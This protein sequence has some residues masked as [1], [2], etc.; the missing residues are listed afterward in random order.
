MRSANA[1]YRLCIE[2]TWFQYTV[3]PL[4]VTYYDT[5][6]AVAVWATR[7]RTRNRPDKTG[8]NGGAI[9]D[10]MPPRKRRLVAVQK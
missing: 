5:G 2:R 1:R 6:T 9:I 7:N 10:H 8:I 3:A 4:F